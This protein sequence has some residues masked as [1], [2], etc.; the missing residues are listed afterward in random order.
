MLVFTTRSGYSV[1]AH[2]CPLLSTGS[3][4]CHQRRVRRARWGE[5]WG[6]ALLAGDRPAGKEEEGKQ[7]VGQSPAGPGGIL[8]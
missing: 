4:G 7:W 5:A 3:C 8:P 1:F 6:P 2:P